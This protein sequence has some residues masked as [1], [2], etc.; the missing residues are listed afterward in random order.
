MQKKLLKTLIQW[1]SFLFLL[2]G[3]PQ[4][5]AF[6]SPSYDSHLVT[7]IDATACFIALEDGSEW[8]VSR[9]DQYELLSWNYR[10]VLPIV[11]TPN[12]LSDRF[13]YYLTDQNTGS[14]VRANLVQAPIR[15]ATF[16]V[17]LTGIDSQF[18]NRGILYLSNG[19]FWKVSSFDLDLIRNWYM[20]DLIIIGK[21]NEWFSL[22]THIL[23]NIHTN[24]FVRV[25]R[26]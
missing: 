13:C 10:E 23:I 5:H 6:L 19:T 20:D 24:N 12:Y 14:Y 11:I 3:T 2:I 16:A 7:A 18:Y 9:N 26:L 1:T 25:Q 22:S 8:K 4:A 15:G 17:T 21:N